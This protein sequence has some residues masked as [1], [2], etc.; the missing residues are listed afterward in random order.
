M[1]SS[2]DAPRE[3]GSV[4][5]LSFLHFSLFSLFYILQLIFLHLVSFLHLQLCFYP[6]VTKCLGYRHTLQLGIV[7]FIACYLIL[8]FSNRITGPISSPTSGPCSEGGGGGD[9]NSSSSESIFSGSGSGG[10]GGGPFDN[11]S[12]TTNDSSTSYCSVDYEIGV[13]HNSIQRV[14]LRVWT[15]LFVLMVLLVISRYV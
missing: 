4:S 1:S 9:V 7:F 6:H 5:H 10:G 3:R 13:N 15:F 12:N 8:P 14:P 2:R 11:Y